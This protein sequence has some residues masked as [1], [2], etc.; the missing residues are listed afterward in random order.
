[1]GAK[2]TRTQGKCTSLQYLNNEI[3]KILCHRLKAITQKQKGNITKSSASKFNTFTKKIYYNIII[4]KQK[5]KLNKFCYK[6]LI[7]TKNEI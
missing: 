2:N 4:F 7:I 5:L 3:Y 6:N 1:M